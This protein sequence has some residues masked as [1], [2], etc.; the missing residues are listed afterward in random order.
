M[1]RTIHRAKF[2]YAES[3]LILQNAAAYVCDPGR[4]LR[5]EPWSGSQEGSEAEVV[6]WGSA[7][8]L[9]GLVNVH[10]HLELTRLSRQLTGHT[11]FTDWLSQLIRERR[12]WEPEDYRESARLGAQQS[13][14]S[15]TTL[16]GDISASGL[17]AEALANS[18]LRAVVFEEVLGLS[19]EK[20]AN[21]IAE[22]NARLDR[23]TTDSLMIPGVSPHA[24]YSVSPQLYRAAT[25]IAGLRG[26][27]MA[28]HVA[29]TQAEQEFLESGSGEF[30]DFLTRL[31]VMPPGWKAP[32]LPPIQYLDSLGALKPSAI[33]IH[34]NYLDRE[35]MTR[36]LNTRCSVAYCPR[37]HAFFGHEGHPVRE[38]LDMGINVALGTDSL[39]S[40]SSLSI[41]DE[42]RFLR[43]TRK[44]LKCEE[45]MR[46]ATL[47]GAAALGFGGALGRLRRG[48]WADMTV[49]RLP[50][51]A[52]MKNLTSQI[53]EGAGEVIATI[54]QGRIVWRGNECPEPAAAAR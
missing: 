27:P 47:N 41:L 26:L 38:L 9:P 48:Y 34:C 33:L 21:G 49:L 5:I 45:I 37:S 8:I 1:I 4:I 18:G 42:T 32:Q 25:E 54:V 6:D 46:M 17:S 16:V 36:I 2:I 23:R 50:K 43:R 35:S 19:E 51:E 3:D 7:I 39:A 29:E 10:T 40:N 24:P 30:R 11:S 20:C 31:G 15:G 52:A 12:G 28:T 22:L 13:V 14:T 53:L 44:D